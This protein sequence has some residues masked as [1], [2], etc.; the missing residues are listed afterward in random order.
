MCILCLAVV[1]CT[2]TSK[3]SNTTNKRKLSDNYVEMGVNYLQ[4]GK[5]NVALEKL[6]RA[7]DIDDSNANAH[8]SIA[9]FYERI[10]DY[11]EAEDHFQEALDLEPEN[12]RVLNNYGRFLC[13]QGNID[14]AMV[15]LTKS[16]DLPLNE[17]PWFALTN[18]GQCEFKR[19]NSQKAEKYFRKA[20]QSNPTYTPT[21]LSLAEISYEKPEYMKARAF[22]E[23]YLSGN[24]AVTPKVLILGFLV[25]QA[26]N[27]SL[28]AKEY[29]TEL[30]TR[31][32]QSDEAA[33]VR[34]MQK[35]MPANKQI[36]SRLIEPVPSTTTTVNAAENS[37]GSVDEVELQTSPPP[38][39]APVEAIESDS[40]LKP[41][42]EIVVEPDLLTEP[43]V[44]VEFE[45]VPEIQVDPASLTVPDVLETAPAAAQID[46][47]QEPVLTVEPEMVLTP[48]ND[49]VPELV[50]ESEPES[51][52]ISDQPEQDF[53]LETDLKSVEP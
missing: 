15:Y 25:E 38:E 2:S 22:L 41:A 36:P 6:E 11:E 29:K 37:S 31:F 39:L 50:I 48:E 40:T 53:Q 21:L 33:K 42:S 45:A 26:L 23:R 47:I 13:R 32:P 16:A 24:G 10:R 46:D 1:S 8:N 4:M 17:R 12:P 49:P 5:L 7:V 35:L 43:D 14:Q 20:L 44:N 3:K 27:Q 28:K 9:V 51:E 30:L 19:G 18:A 52:L 34:K